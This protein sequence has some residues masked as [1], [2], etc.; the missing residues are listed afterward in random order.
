MP[1]HHMYARPSHTKRVWNSV[2]TL[3]VD[4]AGH[5]TIHGVSYVAEKGRSWCERIWWITVLF[6]SVLCCGQ[7]MVDVW[8]RSPIIISFTEKPTPIWQLPFPA[9]TICPRSVAS[10][11]LTRIFQDKQNGAIG[12]QKLSETE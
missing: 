1:V 10:L 9:V 5:S 12:F 4:Y 2:K 11:K 7:L 8:S 6:I 3:F